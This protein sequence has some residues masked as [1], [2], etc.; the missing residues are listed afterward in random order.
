MVNLISKD[1]LAKEK[2][3][4]QFDK[5]FDLRNVTAEGKD[6]VI[7]EFV[8]TGDFAT[9]WRERRIYE[10]DA[11]RDSE[12]ILYTPLYSIVED[13]SLPEIVPI[14]R[15]GPAGVIFNEVKEGGEAHFVTVQSGDISVRIRWYNVALEYSKKLRMY[16]QLWTVSS[17]ERQVG[18]AHNALLNNIHF[19]PILTASYAAANQTA[20]ASGQG[21]LLQN[22]LRTIENGVTHAKADG[23]NPRRGPYNLVISS[24]NMFT[25]ERAL[26]RVPQQGFDEQSSVLNMIQNIIVYDGWTGLRGKK[27]VTY[28]GVTANKAYLVNAGQKEMDFLSFVKQSLDMAVGNADVSRG[29]EEQVVWDVHLGAYANPIAAVEEITLPTSGA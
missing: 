7:A 4:L 15:L 18:V 11:G 3:K 1:I 24:S 6:G 17:V 16:N 13:A 9:A 22:V 29:I 8:G 2:P 25:V 19:S 23:T 12:P 28:S 14:Y 27:T 21:G 5:G 10:I 26:R 20:A